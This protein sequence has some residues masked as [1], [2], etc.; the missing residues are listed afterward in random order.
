MQ[1]E[2]KNLK[3][4]GF[5]KTNNKKSPIVK[6]YLDKMIGEYKENNTNERIVLDYMAGMTDDYL[7]REYA[8]IMGE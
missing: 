6:S 7:L 3:E 2:L 4:E 8:R 1:R 5:I